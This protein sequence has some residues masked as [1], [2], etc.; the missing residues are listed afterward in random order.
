M[1]KSLDLDQTQ[2]LL[3]LFWFQTVCK[4]SQQTAIAGKELYCFKTYPQISIYDCREDFDHGVITERVHSNNLEMTEES[5][6]DIITA[7][8]RWSHSSKELYILESQFGFIF[9]IIPERD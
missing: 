4:D 6:C 3:G 1:L 2:H 5:R 9:E 7:A 8:T